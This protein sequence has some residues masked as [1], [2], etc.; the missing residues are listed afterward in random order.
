MEYK[1]NGDDVERKK[2]GEMIVEELNILLNLIESSLNRENPVLVNTKLYSYP[3]AIIVNIRDLSVFTNHSLNMKTP[4]RCLCV[5]C[6]KKWLK[7][8][9]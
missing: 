5:K 1:E 7:N 3:K 9:V 2:T 8:I 6:V 4:K